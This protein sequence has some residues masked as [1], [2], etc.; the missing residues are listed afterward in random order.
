MDTRGLNPHGPKQRERE[1]LLARWE[2]AD[3]LS[4]SH[5]NILPGDKGVRLAQRRCWA[6]L[7]PAI[8]LT[9]FAE[10]VRMGLQLSIGNPIQQFPIVDTRLTAHAAQVAGCR[11]FLRKW[12]FRCHTLY[13]PLRRRSSCSANFLRTVLRPPMWYMLDSWRPSANR[14]RCSRRAILLWRRESAQRENAPMTASMR[15]IV[16]DAFSFSTATCLSV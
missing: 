13:F 12:V 5:E 6:A 9:L 11:F 4:I 2:I 16:I 1:V 7:H 10:Q 8:A 3:Q 15:P 14:G